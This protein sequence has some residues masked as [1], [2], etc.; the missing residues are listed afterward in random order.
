MHGPAACECGRAARRHK[1][2]HAAASCADATRACKRPGFPLNLRLSP[3]CLQTW[4]QP[5]HSSGLFY[6][7]NDLRGHIILPIWL[8]CW[9]HTSR[10][11]PVVVYRKYQRDCDDKRQQQG[12]PALPGRRQVRQGTDVARQRRQRDHRQ[13]G[14]H[15]RPLC[16]P[17]ER[18]L[19]PGCPSRLAIGSG[20]WPTQIGLT[21]SSVPYRYA[22]AR[23]S[24]GKRCRT[25]EFEC[26]ADE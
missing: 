19:Q 13:A 16:H 1:A 23:T 24:C 6:C 14:Q 2:G 25:H 22:R 4:I 10:S 12:Q 7:L 18:G 3:P 20:N 26:L 17:S 21:H 9:T 8:A 11:Q 15:Q 5:A